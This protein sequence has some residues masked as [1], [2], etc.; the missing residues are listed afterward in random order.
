MDS[1]F[2]FSR[3][4]YFD[5]SIFPRSAVFLPDIM[6]AMYMFVGNDENTVRVWKATVQHIFY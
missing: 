4:Q 3:M 6:I 1:P 5:E 2:S